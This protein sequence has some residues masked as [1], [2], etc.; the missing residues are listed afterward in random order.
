M[1]TRCCSEES[2]VSE[3][4]IARAFLNYDHMKRN[5]AIKKIKKNICCPCKAHCAE[6][7]KQTCRLNMTLSDARVLSLSPLHTHTL[8]EE[9]QCVI[10]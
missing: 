7:E 8:T 6:H 2:S 3:L 5:D 9:V 10:V 1:Q 4:E